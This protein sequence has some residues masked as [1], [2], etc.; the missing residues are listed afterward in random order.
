MKSNV[1]STN[2]LYCLWWKVHRKFYRKRK[3][4]ESFVYWFA[5]FCSAARLGSAFLISIFRSGLTGRVVN[6]TSAANCLWSAAR[7]MCVVASMKLQWWC[8]RL[9]RSPRGPADR[10]PPR[11]PWP[12][13]DTGRAPRFVT[14]PSQLGFTFTKPS[15]LLVFVSDVKLNSS[16]HSCYF[17]SKFITTVGI[18]QQ[19]I[20]FRYINWLKKC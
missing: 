1:Y 12:P 3:S 11:T 2:T 5:Q 8:R 17:Y 16:H 7:C 9:G 10:C 6:V 20:C 15:F 4:F 14:P 19:F 18:F 13:R